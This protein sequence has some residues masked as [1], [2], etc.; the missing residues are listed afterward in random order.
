M[1]WDVIQNALTGEYDLVEHG[2]P[3][4][5]GWTVVAE[6]ANPEYLDYL[7]SLGE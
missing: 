4:P 7:Q 1:T 2:A 5:E 3:V 6:T